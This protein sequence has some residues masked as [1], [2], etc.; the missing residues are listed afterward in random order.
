MHSQVIVIFSFV[1]NMSIC[2]RNVNIEVDPKVGNKITANT[3]YL[4]SA[5]YENINSCM[6]ANIILI[7]HI[8]LNIQKY[9]Y[10]YYQNT[11][12]IIA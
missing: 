10:I 3:R 2:F 7:N 11:F 4:V 5:Q 8:K 9:M 1:G 6:M 12:F